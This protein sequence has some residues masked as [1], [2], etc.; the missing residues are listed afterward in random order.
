MGGRGRRPLP[1]GGYKP[2]RPKQND[3][4]AVSWIHPPSM[5]FCVDV[6][7]MGPRLRGGDG[8]VVVDCL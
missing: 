5:I 6:R 8:G 3:H 4:R 1:A 7:A 2:L